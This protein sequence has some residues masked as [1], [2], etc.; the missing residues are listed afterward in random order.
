[1]CDTARRLTICDNEQTSDKDDSVSPECGKIFA[2]DAEVFW[3]CCD[4]C[5]HWF[6]FGCT[7]LS[8]EEGV[9]E[10]YCCGSYIQ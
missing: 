1:M 9:P 3:I 10:L 2:N 7:T 4:G 6:D 8:S 5:D